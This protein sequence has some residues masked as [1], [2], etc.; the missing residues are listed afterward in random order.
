M[1][2]NKQPRLAE[3]APG[4][5]LGRQVRMAKGRACG[6]EPDGMRAR[7]QPQPAGTGEKRLGSPR[8]RHSF[9]RKMLLWGEAGEP[10]GLVEKKVRLEV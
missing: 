8:G 5:V 2:G 3:P 1:C 6:R 10:W 7:G 4:P 9:I